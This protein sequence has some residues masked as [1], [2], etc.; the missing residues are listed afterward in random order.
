MGSLYM[1]ILFSFLLDVWL[2]V[3][4]TLLKNTISSAGMM[5]FPTEWKVEVMFQTTNQVWFLVNVGFM[6]MIVTINDLE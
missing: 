4:P 3:E 5:E 6:N 1:Y 2:V